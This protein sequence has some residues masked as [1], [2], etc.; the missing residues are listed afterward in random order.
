M[1]YSRLLS[2]RFKESSSFLFVHTSAGL[3]ARWDNLFIGVHWSGGKDTTI[4]AAKINNA[5]SWALEHHHMPHSTAHSLDAHMSLFWNI[6][7]SGFR[8]SGVDAGKNATVDLWSLSES[9]RN[10]RYIIHPR[11]A[12]RDGS[13]NNR[14]NIRADGKA[15]EFKN[16]VG[17]FIFY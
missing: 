13:Q 16:R 7:S 8:F 9:C 3:V 17:E 14:L 2:V 15:W 5:V 1:K 12:M 11:I 4:K 10:Q 6:K